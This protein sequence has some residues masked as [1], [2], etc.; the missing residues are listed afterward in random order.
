[1]KTLTQ[2]EKEIL[3]EIHGL[4]EP[5]QKKFA[6]IIHFLRAELMNEKKEENRGTEEFLS[7]C[8]TW[9]D[10]RSRNEQTD[11]IYSSRKSTNRI[12]RMPLC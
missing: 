10:E 6:K 8:R 11:D 2:H 1:M 7:V 12:H 9:E 3:K 4:P 5:L